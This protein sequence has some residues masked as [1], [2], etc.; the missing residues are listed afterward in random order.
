MAD[1]QKEGL[2]RDAGHMEVEIV[3]RVAEGDFA[4]CLNHSADDLGSFE[5]VFHG[6]V[7]ELLLTEMGGSGT[8]RGR[9]RRNAERTIVSEIYS[10][11]SINK[12]I[13]ELRPKHVVFGFSFD[14]TVVDPEG[15]MPW[16]SSI[17]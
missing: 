6:C 17:P 1:W 15:G 2:A 8:Q 9:E 7:T 16:D 14:I 4:G 11:P 3:N 5:P 13:R 10:P 12:L